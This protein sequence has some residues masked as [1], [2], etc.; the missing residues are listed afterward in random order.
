MEKSGTVA[1]LDEGITPGPPSPPFSCVAV[2]PRAGAVAEKPPKIDGADDAVVTLAV[3]S[4]LGPPADEAK[5]ADFPAPVLSVTGILLKRELPAMNG[6]VG[7]VAAVEKL[8]PVDE[9]PNNPVPGGGGFEAARV[10]FWASWPDDV[11]TGT[12]CDSL[13]GVGVV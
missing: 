7:P 12:V 9:L 11:I 13:G 4:E 3:K 2:P 6:V 8:D 1:L 10:V 5:V